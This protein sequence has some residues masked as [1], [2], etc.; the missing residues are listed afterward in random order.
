VIVGEFWSSLLGAQ[1][2]AIMPWGSR[3]VVEARRQFVALAQ[4]PN[5]NI[6]ALC[7]RYNVSYK[8][9]NRFREE[10][11]EGINDRS[12]RPRHSPS[13][14]AESTERAV[15]E[16]R[17]DHPLWSA[18]KI[19]GQLKILGAT[20]VPAPSTI[21]AILARHRR[22]GPSNQRSALEWISALPNKRIDYATLPHAVIGDS[23]FPHA[24]ASNSDLPIL[25]DH[26]QK[27]GLLARRRSMVILASRSGL[28][29]S[30]ICKILR[31][32]PVTYRR[33]LRIFEEGGAAA[34]FA[35]RINPHRKF[36]N[37]EVK[38]ALFRVLHQPPS[39]FGINRT[40]WTMAELSRVLKE[41]GQAACEDVIRQ[42]I[43]TAGYR[44]RKARV[45]LTSNDPEF[46][47]KL[48]RIRSIL[49]ELKDDEAFFSIDEYGPFAIKAQPGRALVGPG[50]QRVVQQWQKSR[51]CLILTA[52]IELS[53]NQVSHFYSMKKNTAEMVRMMELLTSQYRDRRKVY[54]SWDGASWHISKELF[55]RIEEHNAAVGTGG[56]IVETAPLPSRAQFLN[57][58]ESIFSGMARAIIHNSDYKSV[59]EAKAAIDR[60]FEERNAHFKQ[61]PKRA[62]GKIWR[63]EREP[64]EFSESNNCKDPR[65]G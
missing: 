2:A 32:S 30:F 52:A 11:D 46:S 57:V 21:T 49:S 38:K 6:R 10:H 58:I 15:L 28:R 54:L 45:V 19:A 18:R 48:D 62:G 16:V 63:K 27:G 22:F 41:K 24:L 26:L 20:A 4:L 36:D 50:E 39:N 51:G 5:A 42:I 9:L 17:K 23:A 7:R 25:L 13:R 40:S 8:I 33:S 31:L 59:E 12:R 14:S 64:A 55:K 53:T 43:K 44:W 47:K 35:R 56:P 37:E 60:Y 65:L 34:L 3:T 1:E 29:C 61:Y